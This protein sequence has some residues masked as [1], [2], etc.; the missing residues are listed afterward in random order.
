MDFF[1][2]VLSTL[3]QWRELCFCGWLGIIITARIVSF[4]FKLRVWP[5]NHIKTLLSVDT[6]ERI[7][8]ILLNKSQQNTRTSSE[9][10]KE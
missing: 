4:V 1:L 9:K 5:V 8:F 3:E 6:S 2:F 10:R 7:K